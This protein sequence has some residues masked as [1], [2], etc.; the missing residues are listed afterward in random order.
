M[1][2]PVV[3]RPIARLEVDEAMGWYRKQRVGL[4]AEFKQALE[5]MLVQSAQTLFFAPLVIFVV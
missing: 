3:F 1:S 2:L 5:Q 4:E